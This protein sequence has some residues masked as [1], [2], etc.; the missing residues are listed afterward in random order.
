MG[1]CIWK[2][3]SVVTTGCA[4]VAFG[5]SAAT[6]M[7]D[8]DWLAEANRRIETA[9][10]GEFVLEL[11]GPSGEPLTNVEITTRQTGSA[12]RFGTC[13]GGNPESS[14]DEERAYFRFIKQTF[15]TLV[16]ENAMKWYAAETQHGAL[17][18]EDADRLMAFAGS[19]GL[20]MRGHCLFWCKPKFVQP[21]VQA[22]DE[23]SLRSA[24]DSRLRHIVSR[25]RGRLIAWDVNNEMLDG[26]FFSD[27]LGADIDAW[28]FRRAREIDP[29]VPLFVNEYGILCNDAKTDRYV[30]LIRRL[31]AAGAKVGGIGIQEH[32]AE[33]FA[34]SAEQASAEVDRPERKGNAPLVPAEVWRRLDRL[35]EF[36][37]PIHITEVSSKTMDQQRRADTLEMLFRVAF[38]HP[39]VEA[40]MLWG[41]WEK[42]HWLGKDAALVDANWNLLPA[43][44]RVRKL[45]LDEWRTAATG[46]TD[47]SGRMRFRGFYG[48]YEVTVTMPDG[49]KARV[50]A[51]FA[52]SATTAKVSVPASP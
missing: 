45:L 52:P 29:D 20:A 8:N 22:L 36:G 13:V 16:C 14:D 40:V 15:N 35:A 42:R 32:S 48:D 11:A 9:R 17:T 37:V 50:S 6:A 28:M 12:F 49:A 27:R 24:M 38:A 43:G 21:W 26:S 3:K 4:I 7:A 18:C 1:I 41:F 25:Y 33:R 46:R 47:G 5:V 10:K 30:A 34:P 23:A 44:E 19:N 2:E 31:Q 39:A 51:G